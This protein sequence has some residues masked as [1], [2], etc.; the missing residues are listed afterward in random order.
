MHDLA[1]EIRITALPLS[2]TQCSRT[3]QSRLDCEGRHLSSTPYKPAPTTLNRNDLSP[4]SRVHAMPLRRPPY[5]F[6]AELGPAEARENIGYSSPPRFSRTGREAGTN[7]GAG[8]DFATAP[9]RQV[10][11]YKKCVQKRRGGNSKE[12]MVAWWRACSSPLGPRH[13]GRAVEI[14]TPLAERL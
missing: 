2:S 10:F 3:Q 12:T 13:S 1:C 14:E 5:R 4:V 6:P 11:A 7:Y 8:V 9:S